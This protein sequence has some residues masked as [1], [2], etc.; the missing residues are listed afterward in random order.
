MAKGRS[1]YHHKLATE[2][3]FDCIDSIL[4]CSLLSHMYLG[5]AKLSSFN[6]HPI[7]LVVIG[8][9][10]FC[11]VSDSF[12]ND[13]CRLLCSLCSADIQLYQQIWPS[14]LFRIEYSNWLGKS[15]GGHNPFIQCK[16]L[17]SVI[18]IFNGSVWAFAT[19]RHNL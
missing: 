3:S 13:E 4:G 6:K 17:I 7:Y 9:K 14:S 12:C 18:R 19:S 8:P 5:R 15:L 11:I 16:G 1:E 10:H 2:T